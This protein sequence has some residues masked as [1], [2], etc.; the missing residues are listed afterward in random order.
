MK[1]TEIHSFLLHLADLAEKET[2]PRFRQPCSVDNKLEYGFDPVTAADRE[3]ERAI[4]TAIMEHW[5]NHGV[6]GEEHGSHQ[7]EAEFTWV[8]DPIDGTKAFVSGL[9]VWGTLIAL[10]KNSFPIAGIMAQPYTGEQFLSV[11]NHTILRHG[12]N[13]T[14]ISTSGQTKL[15]EAI[16]MTTAP[17]L[18]NASEKLS[19]DSLAKD[20]KLVR[21]GTDCYAY[22]MLAAGH[23]H[24]VAE[25]GLNFY[26]I[27]ALV[28][29]IEG[30]GGIVT[31][32]RGNK[33][34]DGGE[35]LAA[36]NAE[37]HAAA[38]KRLNSD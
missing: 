37:V 20:C 36:A 1:E 8:I 29:I 23:I 5:P 33:M 3:A 13:E 11:G 12:G 4:K 32:W 38:L 18:F 6:I 22:C 2:L 10:C 24:L 9:P 15:S 30:A 26:D 27:A 25:S 16:L 34:I 17:E 19:F 14:S 28:P 21:Y 35:V 7:A 31:D